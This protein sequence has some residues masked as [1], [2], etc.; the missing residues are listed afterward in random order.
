MSTFKVKNGSVTTKEGTYEEGEC[1]N[2]P[3]DQ[4]HR[5]IN[6]WYLELQPQ[7]KEPEGE[8]LKEEEPKPLPPPPKPKPKTKKKG[9]RKGAKK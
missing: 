8:P 9:K 4:D 5:Y 6:A 7:D 2:V 3:D 1:F